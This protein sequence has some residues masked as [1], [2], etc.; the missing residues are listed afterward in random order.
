[1]SIGRLRRRR[2]VAGEGQYLIRNSSVFAAEM[3]ALAD[4]LA[5]HPAGEVRADGVPVTLAVQA[6]HPRALRVGLAV[7][8]AHQRGEL[9]SCRRPLRIRADPVRDPDLEGGVGRN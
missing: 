9:R 1:M 3:M 7:E 6:Q 8:A 5:D 4:G 2:T